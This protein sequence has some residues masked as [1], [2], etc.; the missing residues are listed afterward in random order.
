[1]T[2]SRQRRRRL[3]SIAAALAAA[4]AL[5]VAPPAGAAPSPSPPPP[6][7]ASVIGGNAPSIA[8][9][10]WLAFIKGET[11]LFPGTGTVPFSCTGTVVAPRVVL[12]AGH[13]I[14]EEGEYATNPA[15]GYR[16]TTGIADVSKRTSANVSSVSRVM[17]YP[18]FLSAKVQL[19]SGLL[20][21]SAPVSAPALALATPG[22]SALLV[23]GTPISIA[24]WGLTH[25]RA[26]SVPTVLRAGGLLLQSPAYCKRH[27]TAFPHEPFYSAAGD[28]CALDR[29]DHTVS[30]CFGDSGGPAIA[31]RADG[32]P[33][34]VG[35]IVGGGPECSRTIP[36][37]YT[38]V[39]RISAW[40]AGWIAAVETG[41]PE[42]PTPT[43]SPPYVFFDQA[44]HEGGVLLRIVFGD[45]FRSGVDKRARC[46]R[47]DWNAVRCA[48]SWHH[49]GERYY[50]SFTIRNIVVGE[51]LVPRD[52][53]TIHRVSDRCR[54]GAQSGPCRV[55]T[56]SGRFPAVPRR[57]VAVTQVLRGGRAPGY[58]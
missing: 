32:T 12:T 43:A 37:L 29:P 14:E 40:V 52:R 46:T 41:A 16:V 3:A 9:Y 5:A 25:P 18:S 24:G 44:K 2:R 42:P 34:E 17:F 35:I 48:V 28:L 7:Q 6:A 4:I 23:G 31:K 50:G 57:V 26:R 21:L 51:E 13:C 19:D 11:E 30:G 38:R 22:D 49:G 39:D 36:N 56:R 54:H 55:H 27:A 45:R 10:P 33:V 47:R 8:E 15:S 53:Y 1:M 20:I 58:R